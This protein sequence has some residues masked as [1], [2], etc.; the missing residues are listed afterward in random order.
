MPS[1]LRLFFSP[2]KYAKKDLFF[3]VLRISVFSFFGGVLISFLLSHF[4]ALLLERNVAEFERLIFG[5]LA[6]LVVFYIFVFL[7]RHTGTANVRAK[8][9]T[10]IHRRYVTMVCELD[11]NYAESLGSG[12]IFSIIDKGGQAWNGALASIF[13]ES[14]RV[15]VIG[16]P[17]TILLARQSMAIIL[18]SCMVLVLG[19]GVIYLLNKRLRVYK[20]ERVKAVTEYDRRFIRSIQSRLEITQNSSLEQNLLALDKSNEVYRKSFQK[21]MGIQMLIFQGARIFSFLILSF[22]YWTLGHSYLEGGISLPSLI[23]LASLVGTLS[24]LFSDIT[25]LYMNLSDQIVSI[26]QLWNKIEYAPKTANLFSGDVFEYSKGEIRFQDVGFSYVSGTPI[27]ENLSYVF[28]A[29]KRY[30][31]VGPSGGGKTTIMKLASGFLSAKSG[32]VLVDGFDLRAVNLSTFYSNIGYLTQDPQIFDGTIRE[33]LVQGK[34]ANASESDVMEALKQAHADF[35]F[36]L[37]EGLE[38]E[39]GER[40]VKLSGGQK[41]RLAIAKI[42]LKDP[43]IILLDE[44]TSAL[45]SFS[46][47]KIS[48]AFHTLFEGRTVLIIAHRLQTVKEADV[49]LVLE[50]GKIAEEGKHTELVEKGGIYARMLELQSGF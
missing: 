24:N 30:A 21:Q 16:L 7:I 3:M 13:Q 8:T 43:H 39:I 20:T 26:E 41:Q 2:Y 14:A 32:R 5:F 42:F 28:E 9:W 25:E 10:F 12:R 23:L 18:V 44:P 37:P 11:N 50:G 4:S 48:Q 22:L 46:E 33:N 31:L 17:T 49:I 36:D 15:L 19:G 27:L 40:G 45:D 29:G 38:T 1:R 34:A 47:E 35:V 6:S